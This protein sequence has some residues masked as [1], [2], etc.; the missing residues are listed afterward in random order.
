MDDVAETLIRLRRASGLTQ[1]TLARRAGIPATVLSA[2]ENGR[3]EP[4]ATTMLRI[5]QEAGFEPSYR[6]RPDPLKCAAILAD[7]LSLAEGLPYRPRPL[8]VPRAPW[9]VPGDAS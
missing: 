5:V 9:G 7:V 6:R 1:A 2:Y 4:A 3:R 8:T